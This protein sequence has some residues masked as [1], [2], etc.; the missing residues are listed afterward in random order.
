MNPYLLIKYIHT[1]HASAVLFAHRNKMDI[2]IGVAV[3]SAVQ[4]AVFVLP[5]CVLIAWGIGCPLDLSL[6]KCSRAVSDG[7]RYVCMYV[8][9]HLRMCVCMYVCMYVCMW[10]RLPVGGVCVAVL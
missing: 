2:A 10:A 1:E 7:S 3:G 6:G 4:I 8:C 5:C 9:T